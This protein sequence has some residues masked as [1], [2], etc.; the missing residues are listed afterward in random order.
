MAPASY[1]TEILIP[2]YEQADKVKLLTPN[3]SLPFAIRWPNLN[4]NPLNPNI[5][6][7]ILICYPYT[8][9]IEVV[10]GDFYEVSIRFF[11]CDHILNSHDHSVL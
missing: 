2:K 5:K 7:Q 11:L 10:G 1:H 6:I 3:H 4:L 8:F 9:S